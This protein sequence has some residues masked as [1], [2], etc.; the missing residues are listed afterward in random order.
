MNL[1]IN[2]L[3]FGALFALA[4]WG[5]AIAVPLVILYTPGWV[6]AVVIGLVSTGVLIAIGYW[7]APRR[8]HSSPATLAGVVPRM[9]D[10]GYVRLVLAHGGTL[11]ARPGHIEDFY[12]A[13]VRFGKT[14]HPS[15]DRYIAHAWRPVPGEGPYRKGDTE[16]WAITK[17]TYDLLIQMEIAGEIKR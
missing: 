2:R 10:N 16:T 17:E 5:I 9:L 4:G 6:F 13:S 8:F 14:D 1:D 12:D 15:C 11:D 7:G 3:K